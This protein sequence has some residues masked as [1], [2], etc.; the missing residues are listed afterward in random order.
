[1]SSQVRIQPASGEASLARSS[2]PT[3]RSAASRTFSGRSARLDAG[4]VVGGAVRLVL[5]ELLADRGEL[6]AQQ[7]L[8][9]GLLQPLADVVVDLLGDL[10]LG[11][12]VRTQPTSSSS[13][14]VT[15]G[16]ASSS[17]FCSRVSQGA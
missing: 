16:A 11:E 1:M 8:A 14:A 7:E 6:L 13:R 5:A 9:L 12:V 4:P 3:S 17:I 2:L 10:L 15:S